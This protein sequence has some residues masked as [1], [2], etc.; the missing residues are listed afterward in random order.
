MR[1][2]TTLSAMAMNN[3]SQAGLLL[4]RKALSLFC[5]PAIYQIRP[6]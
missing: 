5:P 6:D 3:L 4:E 1:G 2:P